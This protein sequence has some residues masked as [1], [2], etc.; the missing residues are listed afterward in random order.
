MS[1]SNTFG[2]H[3]TTG[4]KNILLEIEFTQATERVLF[5][6]PHTIDDI[7][8]V[9]DEIRLAVSSVSERHVGWISLRNRRQRQMRWPG[10]NENHV[11]SNQT[12]SIGTASSVCLAVEHY[13]PVTVR[14]ISEN[15]VEVHCK[16]VQMANVV[17]AKVCM[18]GIVEQRIV[19]REVHGCASLT[20]RGAGVCSCR[21][22]AGRLGLLYRERQWGSRVWRRVI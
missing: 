5:G 2:C 14:G 18:K 20:A 4:Q 7:L 9:Q 13:S 3:G 21:P 6:L 15:L 22:F 17:R 19:H 1:K 10:L 11:A 16:P 12:G 8:D